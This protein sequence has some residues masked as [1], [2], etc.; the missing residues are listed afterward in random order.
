MATT[1]PHLFTPTSHAAWAAFLAESGLT[2]F[3]EPGPSGFGT[4]RAQYAIIGSLP[5][6]VVKALKTMAADG[7]ASGV[8]PDGWAC[9]RFKDHERSVVSVRVA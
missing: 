1:L 2:P 8:D 3:G 4:I 6:P 9:Y 5:V 7:N